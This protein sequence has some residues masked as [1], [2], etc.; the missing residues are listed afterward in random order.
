MKYYGYMV[1]V[2]NGSVEPLEGNHDWKPPHEEGGNFSYA[3]WF[4]E[5]KRSYWLL[6]PRL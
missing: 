2:L 3:K 4:K 6:G 1:C 5:E